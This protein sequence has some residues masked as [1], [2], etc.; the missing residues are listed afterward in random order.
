LRALRQ[1]TVTADTA[2][3]LDAVV[4]LARFHRPSIYDAVYLELARRYRAVFATLDVGLA[5]AAAA[6]GVPNVA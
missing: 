4:A 1:Q 6:E 5:Q 3:G 2:P